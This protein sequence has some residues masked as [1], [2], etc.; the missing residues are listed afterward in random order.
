VVPAWIS[1][2]FDLLMRVNLSTETSCAASGDYISSQS[3]LV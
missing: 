1:I 2:E 3:D